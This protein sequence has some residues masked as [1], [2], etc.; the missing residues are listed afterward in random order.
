MFTPFWPAGVELCHRMGVIPVFQEWILWDVF[1]T[2]VQFLPL[3]GS[4]IVVSLCPQTS[5]NPWPI[6]DGFL[7]AV[8]DLYLSYCFCCS[9]A[10][11]TSLPLWARFPAL[12]IHL[13]VP[14]Q[15]IRKHKESREG[16]SWA[17]WIFFGLFWDF[18]FLAIERRWRCSR[19]SLATFSCYTLNSSRERIPVR[20]HFTAKHCYCL[21][22]PFPPLCSSRLP[23]WFSAHPNL[24]C[25]TSS[26]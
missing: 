4:E 6:S 25:Q 13:L 5:R 8:W 11:P 26:D 3:F 2:R 23:P 16:S 20:C 19:N 9:F 10:T 24:S 17:L 18:F 14:Q 12:A 1:I 22:L 15:G 7:C 21:L